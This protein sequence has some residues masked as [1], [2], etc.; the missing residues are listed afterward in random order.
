MRVVSVFRVWRGDKIGG[1]AFV[2]RAPICALVGAFEKAAGGNPNVHVLGVAR[3]NENR[4]KCRSARRSFLLAAHPGRTHWVFVES[5]YAFPCL[6]AIFRPE[7]PRRRRACVPDTRLTRVPGCEPECVMYRKAGLTFG[8]FGES[9]RQACFFPGLAAIRRAK[10]GWAEVARARGHEDRP[11]IARVQQHV[12]H[13]AAK[14][15]RARQL[16]ASA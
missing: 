2:K 7:K 12:M 15:D 14:Q 13:A 8:R 9:R 3:V 5:R 16:P 10:D 6:P 11:A 1:A 4:V